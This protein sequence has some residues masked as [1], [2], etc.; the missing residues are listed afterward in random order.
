MKKL[1]I[2]LVCGFAF[3]QSIQTKQVE[4]TITDW[5]SLS[6]G[7]NLQNYP[8]KL[9]DLSNYI[10]MIDGYEYMSSFIKMDIVG[11]F[12]IWDNIK[13]QG[14]CEYQDL[15]TESEWNNQYGG[16]VY[17]RNP[18][19]F[20]SNCPNINILAESSNVVVND[21]DIT[22]TFH[23]TGMFEDEGVGLQ[24]D[25]NDDDIINIIDVVSLVDIIVG[26]G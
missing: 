11:G 7:F 22:L 10:V 23:I 20:N 18:M 1:L 8:T 15:Y 5:E 3:T 16:I 19:R 14:T 12:D 9:V 2:L 6:D 25:M 13:M 24:G 4:I 17:S 21:R 26:E